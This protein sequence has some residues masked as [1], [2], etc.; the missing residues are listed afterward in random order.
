MGNKMTVKG[1]KTT[2]STRTLK[3]PPYII[4]KL[5]DLPKDSELV[6]NGN[7]SQLTKGFPKLC[8]ELGIG[9]FT[10]HDLR[11]SMATV[12]LSLNI[13]DKIMMARGGWSNPQ[14]MKNIYQI[15]LQDSEDEAD[16]AINAYY[17]GLIGHDM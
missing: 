7:G 12:G 1:T 6:F 13:A 3:I 16:E 5:Q 2:D 15:V 17:E 10:F 9:H 14:T 11:R 4:Q 8:E